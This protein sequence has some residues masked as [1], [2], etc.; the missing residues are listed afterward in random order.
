M[1]RKWEAV[2]ELR[3]RQ[4]ALVEERDHEYG[5][6]ETCLGRLEALQARHWPEFAKWLDVHQASAMALLQAYASPALVTADADGARQLLRSASRQRLSPEAIEGTMSEAALT[7]GVPMTAEEEHFVKT[8]AGEVIV[9]R[10]ARAVLEEQMEVLGSEDQGYVALKEWMGPDT[11]AVMVAFA[12]PRLFDH[13]KELQKACGL[14]LREKS[15]GQHKGKLQITKRGPSLVRKVL[16]LF[17]LRMIESSPEVKAWS[18][19][20]T[21]KT[22]RSPAVIATMRKLVLAAFHVARGKPFDPA[23][24]FDLRRLELKV[25]P[26]AERRMPEPRRTP[27]PVARRPRGEKESLPWDKYL[28][29]SAEGVKA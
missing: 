17:A 27:R 19:A 14:N 2:A 15:S 6:E 21:I 11:A 12:D 22:P 24:L 10:R 3:V 29:N 13:P 25:K 26:K 8:L 20:R 23:K 18:E 9:S 4:R 16:Y 7:L 28:T 5:R 1:T